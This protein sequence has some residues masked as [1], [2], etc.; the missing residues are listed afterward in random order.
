[1]FHDDI[2]DFVIPL[3]QPVNGEF[4]SST[5][6]TGMCETGTSLELSIKISTQDSSQMNSGSIALPLSVSTAI[7]II[8]LT[9][10][11]F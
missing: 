9:A 10:L 8:V 2:E 3:D 1:M 11:I 4:G 6:Y 7:I 5:T